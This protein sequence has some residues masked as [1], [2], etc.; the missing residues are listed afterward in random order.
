MLETFLAT[1]SPMLSMFI[2]LAIGFLIKKLD[3]L[4]ENSGKVLAKLE[5]YVFFPALSFIT[6]ATNCTPSTIS[7]H[8]INVII[9]TIGVFIA[10]SIAIPLSGLF[11]KENSMERGVYKYALTFGNSGYVGDPLVNSLHGDL[12]LSY[13]KIYTLPVSIA[14]Y[15]WG[16]G[17]MIPRKN[18]ES[19]LRSLMNPPMV[20]LFAGII[21]G[22]LGLLNYLPDMLYTTVYS[23]LTTLKGCVGP[24]AM[25][26]A[27]I[28]IASYDFRE[29]ITDKKV[30]FAT[31]LRLIV[32]PTVI[33]TAL[34]GI[35]ELINLAFSLS[36]GNTVL[37]LSFFAIAAPLG[38]NTVVF[39]EAYGGSP[40]TGAG[41]TMI[42]HTLCVITIPLL[43]AVMVL[44]F[45][46]PVIA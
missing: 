8:F 38:L 6:M 26:L 44:I 34:Y 25:L 19:R 15:T 22:L 35:K 33:I 42:S 32:L 3:I 39:P 14:I 4:P 2:F 27:G 11:V 43:Y 31:L 21:F 16:L 13:Y 20:S 1:L 40:K 7:T 24:V 18:G 23:T 17:V 37:F 28:T 29:M 41:M 12:M 5:T 9:S 10:I 30:Y 46:E 45:G 36:V